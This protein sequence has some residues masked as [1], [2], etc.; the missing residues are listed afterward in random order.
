MITLPEETQSM[1]SKIP[2]LDQFIKSVT[3]LIKQ[4]EEAF[5]N[6]LEYYR[7]NPGAPPINSKTPPLKR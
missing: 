3:P 6:N 5:K 2:E 4:A 7:L 1:I